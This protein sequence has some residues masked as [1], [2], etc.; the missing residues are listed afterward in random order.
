MVPG[1][2]CP[3]SVLCPVSRT[4]IHVLLNKTNLM[5]D[6]SHAVRAGPRRGGGGMSA[7]GRDGRGGGAVP[8]R[9]RPVTAV[10]QAYR[11]A[12][13]P[14]PAQERALRSHAGRRGSPG[15]GGCGR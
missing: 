2:Y 6:L 1:I 15:T 10:R 9:G 5:L 13:D 4:C 11:F 8:G 12:L 7:R 14:A 3:S